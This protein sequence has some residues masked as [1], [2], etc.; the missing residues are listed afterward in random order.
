MTPKNVNGTSINSGLQGNSQ[1]EDALCNTTKTELFVNTL[2]TLWLSATCEI[3]P[4]NESNYSLK[5]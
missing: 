2:F 5:L 1:T 4:R 3:R